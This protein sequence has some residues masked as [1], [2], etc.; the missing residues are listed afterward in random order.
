MWSG[1][2][3][4]GLVGGLVGGPVGLAAGAALGHYLADGEGARRARDVALLRLEWRHHAFSEAGP[5]V[6]LTPVWTARRRAGADV[7]VRLD[8]AGARQ[9]AVVTPEADDEE[10]AL[11]T[12]FVPYAGFDG[13]VTVTLE[14]DAARFVVPLPSEVR[15]LGLSGPARLVMALVACARAGGR[16]L[17]KDDVRFVRETFCAAH[18]LDDDGLAWLRA[19]MRALRDAEPERLAPEKVA[20][21]LARHVRDED[22]DDVI[23]WLMRGARSTWPGAAQEAWIAGLAGALGLDAARIA[24]LWRELDAPSGEADRARALA[25]LGLGPG[26]T[27]EQIRAAWRERVMASHPDRDASAD[28]TRRTAELNAAYRLLRDA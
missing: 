14:G 8:A 13:H 26:A 4:G 18:P 11:P 28:A 2:V 9:K 21:R 24:A 15:R 1:K 20:A 25:T 10:I 12:F 22:V 7:V 5:G 16:P 17:A 3:L 23:L 19:W 6:R 27:A